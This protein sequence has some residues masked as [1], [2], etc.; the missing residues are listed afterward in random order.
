MKEIKFHFELES[1]QPIVDGLLID[2]K[3]VLFEFENVVWF[4]P[5][6]IKENDYYEMNEGDVMLAKVISGVNSL[7]NLKKMAGI[8]KTLT[9]FD[10]LTS[11]MYD[12]KLDYNF[13]LKS[14]LN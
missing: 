14:L 9:L 6:A 13:N 4:A 10:Y 7:E 11:D 2:E 5:H 12:L 8:L 3:H 1:E